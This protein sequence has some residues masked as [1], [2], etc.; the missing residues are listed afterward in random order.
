[1]KKDL[2]TKIS[3]K[4]GL[5]GSRALLKFKKNSPEIMLGA[6]VVSIVA[7][8]VMAGKATLNL[9]DILEESRAQIDT[10][11]DAKDNFEVG[12]YTDKDYK[13]DLT[14]SY[15][16]MAGRLFK[17][18][19]P[20]IALTTSG[21]GLMIGSHRIMKKR[22]VALMASYSAMDKAFDEY[23]NRVKA[24]Y[25][26][27][28]DKMFKNG[29]KKETVSVDG[30]E[31]DTYVAEDPNNISQYAKYFDDF[32]K[33]YSNSPEQNRLFLQ[34]QQNYANDLLK[35]RGH[36]FLNEVYDMLGIP[37]TQAGAVVGW[38]LDNDGDNYVD[39]GLFNESD[40]DTR[41]FINNIDNGILLDFNVDGIIHNLI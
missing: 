38:V 22:N 13:R 18:Y 35:A 32:S 9:E 30:T 29:L 34:T 11:K 40:S 10:V 23:R 6:G 19:A 20:A 14:L 17:N 2:M 1:M 15:A 37:R 28:D 12:E 21:I 33:N 36:L 24:K 41:V 3:K 31:Q 26:E 7:G 5:K 27:E 16:Q 4:V 25:G 8:T 39:F